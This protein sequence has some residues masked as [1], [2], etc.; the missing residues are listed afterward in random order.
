M[1]DSNNSVNCELL[2]M[3]KININD[4][5]SIVMSSLCKYVWRM[6]GYEQCL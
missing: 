1:N 2:K 4:K 6:Q 3:L 5:S